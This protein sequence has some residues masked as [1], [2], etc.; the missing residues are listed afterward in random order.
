M[1][2][3]HRERLGL[4]FDHD[5]PLG[6]GRMQSRH[7]WG[8]SVIKLNHT[9]GGAA[10]APATGWSALTLRGPDQGPE[11]TLVDPEGNRLA[12]AP[13]SRESVAVELRVRD[14]A[15]S[16]AFFAA[17]GL[18]REANSFL[19]GASAVEVVED[20]EAS[21]AGLEGPGLRYLTLQVARA[22][23]A[24]ALAL[25]AGASEGMAPRTLGEVARISFVVEPGGNWIELSQRA[26]VV[27]SL[28]P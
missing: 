2:A 5:L 25:E 6:G 23:V 27:G 15:A 12:R 10:S 3:F 11:E 20:P 4:R 13:A 7:A 14:A 26:S 28:D 22:D 21:A 8:D 16:C 17:I 1:L 9:R 24:H 18:P 19:V